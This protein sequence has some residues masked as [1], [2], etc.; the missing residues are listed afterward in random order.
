MMRV[1]THAFMSSAGQIILLS[2]EVMPV[3]IL[4]K[5]TTFP[6]ILGPFYPHACPKITANPFPALQ[7]IRFIL[8]EDGKKHAL[9]CME[10][11]KILPLFLCKA[12][13]TNGPPLLIYLLPYYSILL[14]PML[15]RISSILSPEQIVTVTMLKA[16]F[17]TIYQITYGLPWQ[18][19]HIF[20][21]NACLPL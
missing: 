17:D 10:L 19:F 21:E 15:A 9:S 11:R 8:W 14:L 6:P 5:N 16:Y 7:T 12:I 18:M 2:K 1:A 4:L 3:P 20:W 13:W